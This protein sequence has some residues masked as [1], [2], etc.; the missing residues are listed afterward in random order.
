MG[1]GVGNESSPLGSHVLGQ[2]S[3]LVLE[4]GEILHS[5]VEP[6]TLH[7][8]CDAV[9]SLDLMTERYELLRCQG[10]VC[11]LHLKDLLESNRSL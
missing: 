5:L 8:D 10:G 6:V 4:G 9:S 2:V 3:M 1:R 11:G 7:C